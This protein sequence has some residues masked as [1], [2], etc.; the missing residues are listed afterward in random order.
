MRPIYENTVIQIEVT[1]ACYLKCTHCTRHV[2][3]HRKP[4]FMKLESIREAIRSLSDFPGRIG[5]MG[6]EPTMHPKFGEVLALY[7]E[8]IPDRRRR[9]FWTAGFRWGDYKEAIFGTFDKDRISYNDHIAYDGKHQPLLVAIDEVIEDEELRAELIENCWVQSQWSA[10]ITPKGAFFCEVAASLDWLFDGPGGYPVV[11]GWW[12][13]TPADFA[14][15][16]A[17]YCGQ[18]SAAIPMPAF[19]DG[20]GGRDGPTVDIVSRETFAKLKAVG[21]PK[22]LAGNLEIWDKKITRADLEA[23]ADWAPSHYRTFEAHD[24]ADVEKALSEA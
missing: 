2:G 16:V 1:N 7:R 4:F 18:C 23:L 19:A 20:R 21:S 9:E 24:P 11:P 22:A 15:Q 6:G 17:R 14:D 13:R 10:S 8:M 5:L 12:N 3:H